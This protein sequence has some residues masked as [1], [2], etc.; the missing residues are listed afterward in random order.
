[1]RLKSDDDARRWPSRSALEVDVS[2]T[3]E[4]PK[5]RR[6]GG[7]LAEENGAGFYSLAAP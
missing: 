7:L 4:T 1:M 2:S 6:R 5:F 3:V